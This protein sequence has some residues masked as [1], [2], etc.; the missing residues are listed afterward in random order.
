MMKGELAA[1]WRN[2][3]IADEKVLQAFMKVPREL[4]VPDELKEVAYEDCPLPIPC[5]KTI[6]QPT[7]TIIMLNAL[8]LKE[9]NK[10]LEVG[11]GSG[12]HAA[13]VASIVGSGKV[14]S[15]EVV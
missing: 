7:T 13:L 9:G 15:L 11:T 12:Y 4:F 8:E 2:G 14:I 6:S 10:V 1:A 3:K 5:G